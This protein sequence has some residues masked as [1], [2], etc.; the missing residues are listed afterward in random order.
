M[1]TENQELVLELPDIGEIQETNPTLNQ[2][3]DVVL[4][5]TNKY[6]VKFQGTLVHV[7][8]LN[9]PH[10]DI[11]FDQDGPQEYNNLQRLV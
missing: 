5:E 1:Q 8:M 7:D 6:T 3:A 4:R 11:R 2:S 9:E 10:F